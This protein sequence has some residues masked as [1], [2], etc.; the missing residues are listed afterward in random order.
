[1]TRSRDYTMLNV[2][3]MSLC[4]LSAAVR[5]LVFGHGFGFS[6]IFKRTELLWRSGIRDVPAQFPSNFHLNNLH[7]AF[8]QKCFV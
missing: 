1:M 6:V 3:D 7:T 2:V 4:L 8:D 5:F